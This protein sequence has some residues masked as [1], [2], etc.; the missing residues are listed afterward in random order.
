MIV[1]EYRKRVDWITPRVNL[2]FYST[3]HLH[4][5]WLVHL[6]SSR[7]S[8][9]KKRDTSQHYR[10]HFSH[11]LKNCTYHL[12][13]HQKSIQSS[14][15]LCVSYYSQNGHRCFCIRDYVIG[16]CNGDVTARRW[17]LKSLHSS[18]VLV[19][20]DILGWSVG[21]NFIGQAFQEDWT[22]SPMKLGPLGHTETS[23]TTVQLCA[24]PQKSEDLNYYTA[25]V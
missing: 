9:E 14:T 10:R 5:M 22:L 4:S 8:C 15:S 23:V 3:Q 11:T 12:L 18:G 17:E 13:L 16:F 21:P 24:T 1:V 20:A 6:H 19:V 25:A 7:V 2:F